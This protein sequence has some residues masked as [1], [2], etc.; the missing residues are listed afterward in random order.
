M[1]LCHNTKFEEKCPDVESYIYGINFHG[2]LSEL[3]TKKFTSSKAKL[4]WCGLLGRF[5]STI[6]K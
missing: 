2:F 1:P 6:L 5:T 3:N 4:N